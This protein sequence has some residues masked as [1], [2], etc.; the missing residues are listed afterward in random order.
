MHLLH[1]PKLGY[2]MENGAITG[3]LVPEGSQ[4]AVGDPLYEVETEKNVVQVEARLPGTL[5]KVVVDQDEALGVGTLVA[6]VADPGEDWSESDV[7]A[8]IAAEHPVENA[9]EEA[10]SSSTGDQ[11][12]QLDAPA[13]GPGALA[14][15]PNGRVRA[16]PKVRAVAERLGVDLATVAGTG[17]RGTLTVED[18]ERAAAASPQTGDAAN[19]ATVLERRRLTG[20]PKAMAAG[21]A[22]S[23]AEIPQFVQQFR[24]DTTSLAAYRSAKKEAGVRVGL[25]SVLA[26]A[27]ARAAT[28][29]PEV[30]SSLRGDEL[31]LYADVNVG[32]AVSTDRGLVVPVVA[33]VQALGAVEIDERVQQ[34]V[35]DA[36]R[37]SLPVDAPATITLSNLSGFGVETGLPLVTAPQAAIVFTG[38]IV[39]T[40]VAVDG[41]VEVRPLLGVAVAFDHRVID[42]A[43]GGAFSRALREALEN[44]TILD[45]PAR[46]E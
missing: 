9:P 12:D 46:S 37:G 6:V 39:D 8:A 45:D 27:I 24:V 42:G 36:R 40:P 11:L 18:V 23:W 17:P 7:S 19:G 28:V 4:F 20:V 44:P 22:R 13:E 31:T 26:A 14:A 34:V 21:V 25:T 38:D 16:L 2:T 1:L 41:R 3:W 29:V 43:T 15:P 32:L 10:S 35:E 5:A 33:R 30:N